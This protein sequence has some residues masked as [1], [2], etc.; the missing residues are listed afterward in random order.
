M[1]SPFRAS[2]NL[3]NRSRHPLVK[4][5]STKLKGLLVA[6]PFVLCGVAVG[7]V[8]KYEDADGNVVF[9]DEPP[10]EVESE[11]V[12]LP[13]YDPPST[14]TPIGRVKRERPPV[15][16]L[17]PA[18]KRRVE[19]LAR[20]QAEAQ[21]RRCTEA[22]VALEVLHQ[23]MPVYLVSEGE[24]RA[25]WYG[26]TYEGER[27]YLSEKQRERAI[28]GQLRKLTLNCADPFNEEEWTQTSND[29]L[30]RE[31][32]M[33]ALMDLEL[34]LRPNSRAPVE[35]LEQKRVIV[36]KYCDD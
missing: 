27:A 13:S 32:C 16:E 12:D 23:G 26:D 1:S 21:G 30:N 5:N 4:S 20:E 25:A 34:F 8:Y 9:T 14:P 24:Y 11:I 35:F 29:W 10:P 7:E 36:R 17:D 18:E 31:K 33:A 6:I 19:N 28:D 3:C 22:R 15:E 2:Y